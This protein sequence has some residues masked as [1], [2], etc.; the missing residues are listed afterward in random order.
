MKVYDCVQGSTEWANLRFGIP[1]ASNFEKIVTPTGGK[2]RSADPYMFTLLAERAMGHAEEQFKSSWM[3]R[4]N[5]VEGDAINFYEL[6]HD[7]AVETVGFITNDEG[8]VGCSPD[9]LIKP[10]GTLQ[11]K[12]PKGNTHMS[13]IL[14][15]GK[16]YEEYKP[17][18]QGEIWIAE[19]EWSDVLSYHPELNMAL[20][21]VERDERFINL[22]EKEIMDFSMRLE[23]LSDQLVVKG[24]IKPS[25][26]PP[27][28][29]TKK[30]EPKPGFDHSS[31][32]SEMRRAMSEL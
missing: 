29:P 9:A 26:R 19:A 5:E 18:V 3:E 30:R 24:L 31:V 28:V 1:T 16:A 8:T 14:K 2:S 23:G 6:L 20:I 7:C 17:Q 21:R 10:N 27:F 32:I 15:T 11:I 12:C 22:L 13:Y 4:G 25:W